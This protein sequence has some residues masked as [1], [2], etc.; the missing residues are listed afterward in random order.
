MFEE[1]RETVKLKGVDWTEPEP[2]PELIP[3][4][5][6]LSL[7]S[8]GESTA[9]KTSTTLANRVSNIANELY[10]ET[11]WY[12]ADETA[13]FSGESVSGSS[14]VELGPDDERL[15]KKDGIRSSL[16]AST[17]P[18][19]EE[20]IPDSLLP[21][22][23]IVIDPHKYTHFD[24]SSCKDESMKKI[25]IRVHVG[26]ERNTAQSVRARSPQLPKG[27][28]P[29]GKRAH[30]TRVGHLD[31]SSAPKLGKGGH[32]N[33]YHA[34]FRPPSPIT[35]NAPGGVVSVAAKLSFA[36]AADRDMLQTEARVY[37]SFPDHLSEDWT[38]YHYMSKCRFNNNSGVVSACAVVPKSYG[39]YMP[40]AHEQWDI[41]APMLLVEECGSPLKTWELLDDQR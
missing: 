9:F 8:P 37:Q 33:V 38:G 6:I 39:Y 31:L 13:T 35:V 10:S 26:E 1:A 30:Q 25:Y 41:L 32:C 5:S 22:V 3:P 20:R 24:S 34:L 11:T 19:L 21:D 2:S 36:N 23:L 7:S 12:S 14:K 28:L 16:T 15:N 4:W 17:A 27:V 29:N 18:K 40:E